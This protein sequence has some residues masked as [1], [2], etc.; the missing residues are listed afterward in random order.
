MK[1]I[2]KL[3]IIIGLK[4]LMFIHLATSAPKVKKGKIKHKPIEAPRWW[5]DSQKTR[6]N[7][8]KWY[9]DA[10][11][12]MFIHW[13]ASSLL[14]GE[15]KGEVRRG[16]SEHIM[17]NAKIPV[18]VYKNKVVAKFNPVKFDADNWAKLCKDTGMRYMVITAKHHDG[19]ALWDS[20]VSKN[21]IPAV[22][23]N[24][25]DYLAELKEACKKQGIKFGFYYSH[26]QDWESPYS[27]KNTW[28]YPDNP[29]MKNWFT[30]EKWQHHREKFKKYVDGKCIPQ[31]K[32]LIIKYDPDIMWFDTATW[33]PKEET[34][35]MLETA[36][37]VGPN[38]VIN[39]RIQPSSPKGLKTQQAGEITNAPMIAL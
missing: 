11:F 4:F 26:A 20:E 17:A 38:L 3:S 12:G 27:A 25:R 32:E 21:T 34:V 39:S 30:F 24:K 8:I 23:G 28:D 15:W 16:Y 22:T 9:K 6:N 31:I 35:R 7:R 36:R 2:N 18:E 14:A 1:Y 5:L 10:R 29:P 13:N 37:K 33:A 19:F